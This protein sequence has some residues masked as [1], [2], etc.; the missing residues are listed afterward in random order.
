MNIFYQSRIRICGLFIIGFMLLSRPASADEIDDLKAQIEALKKMVEGLS[1][2]LEEI[3]AAE[4]Q[5]QGPAPAPTREGEAAAPESVAPV[6]ESAADEQASAEAPWVTE[7]MGNLLEGYVAKGKAPRS[8]MIPGTDVS[9]KVGGRLQFDTAYDT[10]LVRSGERVFPDTIAVNPPGAGNILLSASQTRLNLEASTDTAFGPLRAYIEGDFFGP[11]ATIR[12]RHLYLQWG[13]LLAGHTWSTFMNLYSMTQTVTVAPPSGG[14]FKRQSMLRW[15]Q[16]IGDSFRVDI[17]LEEPDTDLTL[18]PPPTAKPVTRWPDFVSSVRYE[19][20]K[21]GH[22]Q[23][24]GIVRRLGFEDLTTGRTEE[25]TGWGLSLTGRT[26]TFGR[27]SIGAGLTYGEGVGNYIAG[28]AT[29]PVGANLTLAGDLEALEA[30][31]TY[32]GYQ[33]IWNDKWRTNVLYGYAVVE[34]PEGAPATRVRSTQNAAINLI[35]NPH[36][37]LGLG[38]EYHYGIRENVDG[39]TGDNNRVNLGIQYAF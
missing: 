36:P 38:I 25:V 16:P 4:Q 10:G 28:L 8:F 34:D 17:A 22:I 6:T 29:S 9:L 5:S 27:D 37:G 35:W 11:G 31:A 33:R 21:V 14:I 19:R 12:R 18:P 24:A 15:S 30:F 1:Q 23:L 3:E 2:R 20:E 39:A 13:N 26:K 32:A 7:P